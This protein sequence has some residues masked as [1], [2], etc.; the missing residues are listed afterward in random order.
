[1]QKTITTRNGRKFYVLQFDSVDEHVEFGKAC[2]PAINKVLHA[3]FGKT[4]GIKWLGVPTAAEARAAI[5][6]GWQDGT[7]RM[8]DAM[9]KFSGDFGAANIRRALV[10]GDHGD[11]MDVH[12]ALRGELDRAWSRRHRAT[13]S[14]SSIVTIACDLMVDAGKSADAIFWR[15]AAVTRL[16]DLLTDA[17]YAVELVAFCDIVGLDRS[18]RIDQQQMTVIKAPDMPLDLNAVS[19]SLCLAGYFRLVAFEAMTCID[20]EADWG[21]GVPGYGAKCEYDSPLLIQ[22]SS[23]SIQ[24]REQAEAWLTKQIDSFKSRYEQAA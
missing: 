5:R 18:G 2:A 11:E 20:E 17:G 3:S 23:K 19:A 8:L 22:A 12:R 16:A 9:S 24:T 6:G 14:A 4:E 10:R 21:L 13:R 1:M 15:G 7:R